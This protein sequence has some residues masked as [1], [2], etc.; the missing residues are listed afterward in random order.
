MRVM[1]PA[2]DCG[3]RGGAC[4]AGASLRNGTT[5]LAVTANLLRFCGPWAEFPNHTLAGAT[6]KSTRKWHPARGCGL[7]ADL[8]L[9]FVDAYH[10]VLMERLGVGEIG[11]F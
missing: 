10:A 1:A 2:P 11:S 5:V 8:N 4:G 3:R 6:R 9:S 7:Y